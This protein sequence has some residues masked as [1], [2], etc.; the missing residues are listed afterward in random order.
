VEYASSLSSLEEEDSLLSIMDASS[1][2]LTS[3]CRAV[4]LSASGGGPYSSFSN[5][6]IIPSNSPICSF[7]CCILIVV[8]DDRWIGLWDGRNAWEYCSLVEAPYV[9]SN[10]SSEV[11][12]VIV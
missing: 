9:S 8:V 2:V 5:A 7:C 12:I 10:S 1:G 11:T 3:M 4:A 6:F